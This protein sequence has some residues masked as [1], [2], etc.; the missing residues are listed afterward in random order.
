M[1]KKKSVIERL[2]EA[3]RRKYGSDE[4][5]LALLGDKPAEPSPYD[6]PEWRRARSAALGASGGICAITSLPA[7]DVHHLIPFADERL[8]EETRAALLT[9][10]QNLICL[11]EATHHLIHRHPERLPPDTRLRLA[12]MM[13]EVATRHR[14]LFMPDLY[15]KLVDMAAP[16]PTVT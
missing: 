10:P 11:T 16:Q 15:Y 12:A 7:T 2:N 3:R 13:R 1:A 6:T 9:D 14:L 5:F 8:P 4:A